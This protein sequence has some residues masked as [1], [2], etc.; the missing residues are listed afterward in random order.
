VLAPF[1]YV[2]FADF[3]VADQLNSLAVVILDVEHF[4]CWV[5]WGNHNPGKTVCGYAKNKSMHLC[6]FRSIVKS[7]QHAGISRIQNS[8]WPLSPKPHITTIN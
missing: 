4:G 7:F 1:F 5:S 2:N 8:M 6:C 3:W